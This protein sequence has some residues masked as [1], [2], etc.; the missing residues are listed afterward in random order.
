MSGVAAG[1]GLPEIGSKMHYVVQKGDTLASIAEKVYGDS[2]KWSEIASFT[3]LSNPRMIYPGDVVY[4]Q[5]TEKSQGFAAAYQGMQRSEV[6]VQEGE[7]LSTIARRVLGSSSA[8]KM[9][10]RENDNID[11]PDRLVA[12]TK[13]YYVNPNSVVDNHINIEGLA[14][15]KEVSTDLETVTSPSA[16]EEVP[17]SLVDL[18]DSEDFEDFEDFEDLGTIHELLKAEV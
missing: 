4:Y 14:S 1:P 5:L 16:Q 7:T 13:L 9:I 18:M 17:F 12:G 15:V 2:S 8:W 10:W 3:G 11:N 6:V